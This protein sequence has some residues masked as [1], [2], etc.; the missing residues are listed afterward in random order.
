[1]RIVTL[2]PEDFD[3]HAKDHEL[4]NPWQTSNFGRAVETLGYSTMYLGFEDGMTIKGVVLLPAEK[5]LQL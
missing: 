1:M 4:A 5:L 2:T 3:I